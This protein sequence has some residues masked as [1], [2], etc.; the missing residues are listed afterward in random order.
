MDLRLFAKPKTNANGIE[1]IQEIVFQASY[2]AHFLFHPQLRQLIDVYRSESSFTPKK[3]YS[4][5]LEWTWINTAVEDD[6]S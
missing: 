2:E 3:R 4:T 6:D 1:V 5:S